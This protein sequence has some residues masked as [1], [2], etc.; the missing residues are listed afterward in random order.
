MVRVMARPAAALAAGLLLLSMAPIGGCGGNGGNGGGG[1]DPDV[2][3]P[4]NTTIQGTVVDSANP[5]NVVGD[6]YVY[7][8]PR[9]RGAAGARVSV[10]AATHSA[11]NGSYTLQGVPDGD[12]TIVVVPPEGSNYAQEMLDIQVPT[13]GTVNLRLTLTDETVALSVSAVQVTPSSVALNVGAQQQYTVTVLDSSSQVVA[14]TPTWTV[15]GGVGTVDQN[16]VFTATSAGSGQV[17]ATV[18]GVSGSGDVTVTAPLIGDAG[19]EAAIR[20]HLGNPAGGL[21]TAQLQGMTG[22]LNASDRSIQNLSGIENCTGLSGIQLT[23]NAITDATALASLTQLTFLDVSTNQLTSL[24]FASSL[25]NLMDLIASDNQLTS[26]APLVGLTQLT[27]LDLCSNQITDLSPLASMTQVLEFRMADNGITNAA[28][29]SNL[30]GLQILDI[31]YNPIGSISVIAGLT[32]LTQLSM[33]H[34]QL[35]DVGT[36]SALTNLTAL[37]LE[38]NQIT[39]IVAVTLLTG[40]R[41]LDLS[42]NGLSDISTIGALSQLQNLDLSDNLVSNL[43][44]LSGLAF[45]SNLNLSYNTITDISALVAN[46][47]LGVNDTVTLLGHSLDLTLNSDDWQDVDALVARGVNVVLVQ[48]P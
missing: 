25:T 22:T 18:A 48:S 1:G 24:D 17:T 37:N 41:R 36:I 27:G 42:G 38:G 11:A 6:A 31:G 12:Q 26:M 5:G 15:T 8:P 32:A 44:P 20:E 46:A 4:G 39:N 35:S 21:T 9:V 34:C 29:L 2:V 10:V 45:L 7:V 40:L 33:A 3:G 16:G 23:N 28:P 13:T 14:L 47:G 43:D 30:A 19:L